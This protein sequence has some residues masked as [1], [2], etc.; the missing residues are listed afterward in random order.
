MLH[1]HAHFGH[2]YPPRGTLVRVLPAG[3]RPCWFH[4]TRLCCEGGVWYIAGPGGFVVTRPPVRLIVTVL[5]PDC[6]TVWIAG[7][8]YS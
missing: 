1:E 6:T 7:V 3:Y 8:A 2:F 4:G 5:P